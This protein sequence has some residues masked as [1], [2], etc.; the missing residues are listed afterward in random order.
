MPLQALIG[1]SLRVG[2]VD[3]EDGSIGSMVRW[4]PIRIFCSYLF[5][6][7]LEQSREGRFVRAI[8][9]HLHALLKTQISHKR[10]Q[11]YLPHAAVPTA[12]AA[13]DYIRGSTNAAPDRSFTLCR[14]GTSHGQ[15]WRQFSNAGSVSTRHIAG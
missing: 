2:S 3:L 7:D 14:C 1:M 11:L 12:K 15:L 4:R 10:L 6:F 8:G 5:N 13:L 9:G